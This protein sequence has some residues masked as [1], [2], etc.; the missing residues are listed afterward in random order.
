MTNFELIP[1][2]FCCSM[3]VLILDPQIFSTLHGV[4]EAERNIRNGLG[5]NGYD[6]A[7]CLLLSHWTKDVMLR[8][9]TPPELVTG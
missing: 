3:H 5:Q 6:R 9:L 8:A 7:G 2:Y 4:P 1:M